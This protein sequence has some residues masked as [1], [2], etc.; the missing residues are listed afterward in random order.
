M[1]RMPALFV[2]HGS[3]LNAVL[4]NPYTRSLRNLSR[5]LPRPAA[6]CVVSAHWQTAGTRVS[7]QGQL[8]QIHDFYG[9]PRELY[10]IRYA[11][12]G[13]TALARRAVEVLGGDAEG[14]VCDGSWGH[15]HA[16]W[17]VLMHLFPQAD[18]PTFFVSV[19]MTAPPSR[20][21]ELGARLAPLRDEGVLILG[22]GNGVHNLAAADFGNIDAEPDPRGV[23]FDAHLRAALLAGDVDA[24]VDFPRWG[25]DAAYSVPTLDHYL[26][27]LWVAALRG[28][29]EAVGFPC[30][31]FQNRSVSMRSVLVGALE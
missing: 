8:R 10:E 31:V 14:I 15:D 24:L 30:E 6:V 19:D 11:P 23:R 2:G 3:P 13:H 20:H 1:A 28:P 7:C 12:P 29:G 27:L 25:A 18:V 16:G 26:P 9:F 21:A 22:S 5:Q 4:D 17:A